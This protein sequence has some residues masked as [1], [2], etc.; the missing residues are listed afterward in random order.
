MLSSFFAGISRSGGDSAGYDCFSVVI[1]HPQQLASSYFGPA[2]AERLR[3]YIFLAVDSGT[4]RFSP[5]VRL[6]DSLLRVV[7]CILSMLPADNPLLS[8]S[9]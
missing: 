9:S 7:I 2:E 6:E 5:T 3:E 1:C 4:E 8:A